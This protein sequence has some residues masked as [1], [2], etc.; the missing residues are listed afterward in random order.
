MLLRQLGGRLCLDFCN[1]VDPR[2]GTPRDFISSYEG[3]LHWAT[4][5]GAIS[6]VEGQRLGRRARAEPAYANAVLTRALDLRE[7]LYRIFRTADS[8][9]REAPTDLEI[10]NRVLGDA[11]AKTRLVREP[12]GFRSALAEGDELERPLWSIAESAADVL[13]SPDV[14]RVRTC[15]GRDCGWLFLD[16]SK[17]R[18]RRWCS[19]DGCGSR[20]KMRR[21]YERRRAQVVAEH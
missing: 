16:A 20:A 7:A 19:M 18:S 12:R 6:D 21:L 13:T 15:A 11:R 17:N 9:E 5:V 10:L 4:N 3:L 2:E 14:E 1:T 8:G